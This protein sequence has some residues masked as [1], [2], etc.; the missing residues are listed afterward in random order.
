VATAGRDDRPVRALRCASRR[1]LPTDPDLRGRVGPARDVRRDSDVVDAQFVEIA[2]DV[3]V[4]QPIEF[5]V[6]RPA[7]DGTMTMTCEVTPSTPDHASTS[8]PRMCP[9]GSTL[10]V[11]RRD[12]RL[13]QSPTSAK[14][15]HTGPLKGSLRDNA[16]SPTRM[17]ASP[18]VPARRSP[19][20]AKRS[21]THRPTR[22]RFH[23]RCGHPCSAG[24]S[25]RGSSNAAASP[26][27]RG[28]R[29]VAQGKKDLSGLSRAYHAGGGQRR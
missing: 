23:P 21:P 5:R 18:A 19:G 12:C 24:P 1:V 16:R 4:V 25:S 22:A 8:G 11:T 27:S 2:P 6:R 14:Q 9:T 13:L 10:Q 28:S 15:D 3:R 29:A 26:A 17:R 20:T 7:L